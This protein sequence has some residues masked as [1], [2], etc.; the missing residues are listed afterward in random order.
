MKKILIS[1]ALAAG[2]VF[3]SAG[4]ASAGDG[5]VK[6]TPNPFVTADLPGCFGNLNATINHDSGIQDHGRD[7]KGPGYTFRDGQ[8]FQEIRGQVWPIFCGPGA[9][10]G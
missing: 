10:T 2:L 6:A 5:P 7:S 8:F 3:A 1:T 9:G 4:S